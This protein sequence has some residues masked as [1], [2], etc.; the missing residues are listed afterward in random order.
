MPPEL[1]TEEKLE[2]EYERITRFI[3]TRRTAPTAVVVSEE[4]EER[5]SLAMKKQP[6]DSRE[7]VAAALRIELGKPTKSVKVADYEEIEQWVGEIAARVEN[8][9]ID[10]GIAVSV[11]LKAQILMEVAS[12]LVPEPTT[13]GPDPILLAKYASKQ[14]A[15]MDA[16]ISETKAESGYAFHIPGSLTH[17]ARRKEMANWALGEDLISLELK[18]ALAGDLPFGPDT[19]QIY[20]EAMNLNVELI[21]L[22]PK[23]VEMSTRG[24]STGP[25]AGRRTLTSVL[26]NLWTSTPIDQRPSLPLPQSVVGVTEPDTID[27][28][29]ARLQRQLEPDE[30]GDFS[31]NQIKDAVTEAFGEPDRNDFLPDEQG[32][33]EFD[34]AV[35]ALEILIGDTKDKA[36]EYRELRADGD[37]VALGD[38]LSAWLRSEITNPAAIRARQVAASSRITA[39]AEE[40]ATADRILD[41]ETLQGSTSKQIAAAQ[42]AYQDLTLRPKSE[43]TPTQ[44][45]A[46]GREIAFSDTPPTL[47]DAER[48]FQASEDERAAV[49]AEGTAK[50]LETTLSNENS[51]RQYVRNQL[52]DNKIDPDS[53]SDEVLDK[54]DEWFRT[55]GTLNDDDLAYLREQVVGEEQ[56][57]ANIE[58]IS[59]E[60]IARTARNLGITRLGSDVDDPFEKRFRD[61]TAPRLQETLQAYVDANPT[62]NFDFDA[63][64][65]RILDLR[66]GPEEYMGALPTVTVTT[67]PPGTFED[68][69]SRYLPSSSV[70]T[71][72]P[73]DP[74]AAAQISEE[75]AEPDPDFDFK[76]RAELQRELAQFNE[77]DTPGLTS[78]VNQALIA[79]GRAP[80]PT[81]G[82]VGSIPQ[83]ELEASK[84]DILGQDDLG[85]LILEL[86]GGDP[87]LQQFLLD[88]V[89]SEEFQGAFNQFASDDQRKQEAE[90][91]RRF[92]FTQEGGVETA[93]LEGTGLSFGGNRPSTTS[94]EA[95]IRSQSGVLKERF[96]RDPSTIQRV[97]NEQERD[98]L[99]LEQ[100]EEREEERLSQKMLRP[101]RST[102]SGFAL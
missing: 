101:G 79:T 100:E 73:V 48:F 69:D 87:F 43:L 82:T 6:G 88:Q 57:L 102:F 22:M 78:R 75:Y 8:G 34:A 20:Q 65:A 71:E 45:L 40:K 10:D 61:V 30:N 15:W 39:E 91:F 25:T 56:R 51:R 12:N 62:A 31:K 85:R 80:L 26:S 4:D 29:L 35:K 72:V 68:W 3:N 54:V 59:D 1:T 24:L 74:V 66:L 32:Q 19:Y 5:I 27:T 47:E 96:G 70:F 95:Y 38:D 63:I 17:I 28:G 52:R 49:T 50:T 55:G 53:L 18:Q 99:K 60:G 44:A 94:Q 33:A 64:T 67:Q 84:Q 93:P 92:A 37:P 21:D 13:F 42:E 98:R 89:Q 81:L 9:L 16:V 90:L 97:Q 86:S 23:L 7:Q 41:Q 2:L 46:F 14:P 76:S 36:K 11:E 58:A 83:S 77:Q